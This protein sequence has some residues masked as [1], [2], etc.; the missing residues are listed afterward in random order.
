MHK[1][2]S[3]TFH[4]TTLP[5]DEVLRQ[6]IAKERMNLEE[7]Q[8]SG[9]LDLKIPHN[10]EITS[11]PFNPKNRNSAETIRQYSIYRHIFYL[12]EAHN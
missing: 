7:K 6:A 2:L 8:K 10:F 3:T 11:P 12:C 5:S 4:Q 1:Y 9:S